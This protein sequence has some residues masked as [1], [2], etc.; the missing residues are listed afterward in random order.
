M[1]SGDFGG[2]SYFGTRAAQQTSEHLVFKL[3][4][5]EAYCFVERGETGL[6]H[7]DGGTERAVL[8]QCTL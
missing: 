1:H 8:L 3:D 7:G 2:I 5:R 6:G 4:N